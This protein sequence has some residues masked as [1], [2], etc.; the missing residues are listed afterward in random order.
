[1]WR[2]LVLS[3]QQLNDGLKKQVVRVRSLRPEDLDD[4]ELPFLAA[5]IGEIRPDTAESMRS[6]INKILIDVPN[7]RENTATVDA[8]DLKG[9][10]GDNVHYDTASQEEIGR[11]FAKLYLEMEK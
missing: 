2:I 5:T 7:H 10:I 1:M 8:R 11:R 4:P 6:E 9:H 3:R